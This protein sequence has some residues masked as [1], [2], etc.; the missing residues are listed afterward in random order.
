[1]SAAS[2]QLDALG[3]ACLTRGDRA[4][5]AYYIKLSLKEKP[6]NEWARKKLAELEGARQ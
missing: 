5:A 3:R 6:D 2:N 4:Q 1:M